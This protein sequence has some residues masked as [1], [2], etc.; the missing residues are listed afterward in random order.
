MDPNNRERAGAP[1]A[2]VDPAAVDRPE[3]TQ[4]QVGGVLGSERPPGPEPEVPEN[5]GAG[6]LRGEAGDYE[7]EPA[8]LERRA[9]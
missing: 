5:S 4:E 7:P 8:G 3:A 9:P 1:T 2:T 6:L